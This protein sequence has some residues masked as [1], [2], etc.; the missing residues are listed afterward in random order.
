MT[1]FTHDQMHRPIFEEPDHLHER[2]DEWS[3]PKGFMVG[4]MANMSFQH[5]GQQYFDAAHALVDHILNKDHHP[6]YRLSNPVLY[7][8]RHSIELFLKAILAGAAKT[9]SLETLVDEYREFIKAEFDADVPQWIITR[10][11]ELAEIDPN[12]TAFRYNKVYDRA[13]KTDNPV[14]GEY[15]VDLHHLRSAMTVL[16]IVLVGVIAAVACGEG[17]SSR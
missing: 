10:M 9:H 16:N 7:L 15:F 8:Y 11:T 6:D 14:A 13:T 3:E 2:T 1:T 17:K 12:S 4:G 5:L